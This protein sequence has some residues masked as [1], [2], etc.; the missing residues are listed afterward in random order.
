MVT[1]YTASL[2]SNTSTFCPHTVFM[3]FVW[4]SEQTAIISLHNINWPVFY[5]TDAVCSL[6]GT[7]WIFKYNSRCIDSPE[8]NLGRCNLRPSGLSVYWQCCLQCQQTDV[9]NILRLS[10]TTTVVP[11][12]QHS[13]VA[14]S[15][16]YSARGQDWSGSWN[17]PWDTLLFGRWSG[18][19]FIGDR[20][21][22]GSLLLTGSCLLRCIWTR[23]RESGQCPGRHLRI[24]DRCADLTKYH[25]NNNYPGYIR[26]QPFTIEHNGIVHGF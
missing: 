9:P 3:C 11:T 26:V 16:V 5:N 7:D 17:F 10:R 12:C 15:P 2:T 13:A 1:I 6:R 19:G 20:V 25:S 18:V 21:M 14:N 24:S 8:G 4:I 23:S 22:S